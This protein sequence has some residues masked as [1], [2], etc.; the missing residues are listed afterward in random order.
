VQ[1]DCVV[2]GVGVVPNT[3]MVKGVPLAKDGSIVV[4][5]LMKYVG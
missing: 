3:Q 5:A 1:A 4:D 2:V